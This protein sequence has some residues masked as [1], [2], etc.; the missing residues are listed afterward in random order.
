MNRND[1]IS[2]PDIIGDFAFDDPA[3]LI[4]VY[5]IDPLEIGSQESLPIDLPLGK[6]CRL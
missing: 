2:Y 1:T 5:P 3:I 6:D 4:G